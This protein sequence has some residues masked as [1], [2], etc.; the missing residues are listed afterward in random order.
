M[1]RILLVDDHALMREGLKQ[2]FALVDSVTVVAEACG[3]A[4]AL[5]TLRRVEVDLVLLDMS[6]PGISGPN[7]ISHMRLQE[8]CP[9]V[10]VLSTHS[11]LQVARRALG[12]GA[13][14][15]LTKD[16][17]PKTLIA[18]VTRVAAGG[19]FIDPRLAEQM[20]FDVENSAQ[21]ILHE[22][23]SDREFEIFNML[24]HGH[25]VNEIAE[26]LVISNKTVSTHKAR[27]MQKMNFVNN[28]QLV[29][30]ALAQ[31]LIE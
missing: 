19:R 4:Q 22:L 1:I 6:M 17:D 31:R 26:E 20:A 13:A 5:E 25:S 12:A 23:L 29:R 30:Y 21:R 8:N 2:L 10:L 15:Y 11:E 9:P 3:G 16:N 27:L 18:A 24:A 7:L 28:A 14:G